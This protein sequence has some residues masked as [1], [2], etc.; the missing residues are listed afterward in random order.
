LYNRS[1]LDHLLTREFIDAT[2][3]GWP[4]SVAFL[5]LDYFKEI[6][7]TYGHQVGDRVLMSVGRQ[8]AASIRQTDMAARYGGEEF[9]VILP[10]TGN[11]SACKVL[12]RILAV[13]RTQEHAI[14]GGE[15]IRVTASVGL[16]VHMEGSRR[17][18]TS[19]DLLHAADLAL[20]RAKHAGRDR[21]ATYQERHD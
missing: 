14:S 11:E 7:D 9:V 4:L 2:E 5:D 13:I 1:R 19:A 20:Y 17:F 18:E 10:G 21:V 6:N 16:A 12:D 3:R 8:I 15:P